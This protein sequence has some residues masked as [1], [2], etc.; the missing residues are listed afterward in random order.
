MLVPGWH[1][2]AA[3]EDR[4]HARRA[5]AR[6]KARR[7][8]RA[9]DAHRS[10]SPLPPER[11]EHRRPHGLARRA[12]VCGAWT[13]HACARRCSRPSE[14]R[15]ARPLAARARAGRA[16]HAPRR[17]AEPSVA[18]KGRG[19]AQRARD[20]EAEV[21]PPRSEAQR[22]KERPGYG[23]AALPDSGHARQRVDAARVPGEAG[24]GARGHA[25]C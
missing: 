22:E 6:S 12:R 5:P 13:E 19:A 11:S 17:L 21:V 9:R 20:P 23:N 16:P 1:E 7:R 15:R 14:A 24:E 10:A 4:G 8:S 25:R 18:V 2:V 3:R